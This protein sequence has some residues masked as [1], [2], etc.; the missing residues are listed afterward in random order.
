MSGSIEACIPVKI[1]KNRTLVMC[2]LSNIK[3]M[4]YFYAVCAVCVTIFCTGGKFQPVLNF[5]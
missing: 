5:M 3:K 2:T 1:I 4:A